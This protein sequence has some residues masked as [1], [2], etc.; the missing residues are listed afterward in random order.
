MAYNAAIREQAYN[1]MLQDLEALQTLQE[2]INL[3]E[4]FIWEEKIA[5]AE[6]PQSPV[7]RS[8]QQKLHWLQNPAPVIHPT[9]LFAHLGHAV[10]E[11]L[12]EPFHGLNIN[13]PQ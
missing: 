3:L 1:L 2:Q 10:E 12:E 7:L 13:L 9:N 4:D 8:A 6:L 5:L 11:Q